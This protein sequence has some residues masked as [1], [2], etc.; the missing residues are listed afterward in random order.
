[1]DGLIGAYLKQLM[2]LGFVPGAGRG[3]IGIGTGGFAFGASK[4][5]THRR[6]IEDARRPPGYAE[7]TLGKTSDLRY[8]ENPHQQA[9]LH[10]TGARGGIGAAEILSGK[11]MSFNN[12][13]DADA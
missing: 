1:Y 12:Y 11:E 7:W 4:K 8:G 10:K 6:S 3:G 2:R 13:V 5:T 9:A